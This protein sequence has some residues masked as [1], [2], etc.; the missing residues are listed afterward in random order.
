MIPNVAFSEALQISDFSEDHVRTRDALTRW[1]PSTIGCFW[2]IWPLTL[3]CNEQKQS[4]S[5]NLAS[6][7]RKPNWGIQSDACIGLGRSTSDVMFWQTRKR[8]N[9]TLWK[10]WASPFHRL[11]R[12]WQENLCLSSTDLKIKEISMPKDNIAKT[13][14]L[15][16]RTFIRRPWTWVAELLANWL[17]D[18]LENSDY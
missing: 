7:H 16:S 18:W 17:T 8:Q 13:I 15:C 5:I 11:S 12:Q 4:A 2:S 6:G 14:Y 9:W 1:P 3:A 10:C